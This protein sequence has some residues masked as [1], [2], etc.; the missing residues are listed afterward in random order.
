M[1][2]KTA[3]SQE[4]MRLFYPTRLIWLAFESFF[5][6]SS[7]GLSFALL[8][9][10][11]FAFFLISFSFF[12]FFF[13]PSSRTLSGLLSPPLPSLLGRSQ[14]SSARR[15]RLITLFSCIFFFSFFSG[16]PLH[17]A[18]VTSVQNH[19]PRVSNPPRHSGL[20]DRIGH[21]LPQLAFSHASP[22]IA[23]IRQ[24]RVLSVYCL[25]LTTL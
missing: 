22:S 14:I 11:F 17:S 19:P 16:S 24:W 23:I 7:F 3:V 4:R 8:M 10:R 18:F 9:P 25:D 20:S 13:L 15:S 6:F 5:P 2:N 12:F 1:C 21:S